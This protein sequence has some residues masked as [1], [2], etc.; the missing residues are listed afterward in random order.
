MGRLCIVREF[1]KSGKYLFGQVPGFVLCL[2]MNC[3]DEK[4]FSGTLYYNIICFLS[5]VVLFKVSTKIRL[6]SVVK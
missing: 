5:K 2:Y 4:T 1:P 6:R 3:I